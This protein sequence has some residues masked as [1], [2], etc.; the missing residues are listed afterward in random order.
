MGKQWASGS[1]W[2]GGYGYYQPAQPDWH[3]N[4]NATIY[5]SNTS[6]T[7]S[8][9]FKV[10][11][12]EATIDLAKKTGPQTEVERMLAAVEAVCDLAR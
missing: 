4:S 2:N 5:A 11:D 1:S 12:Q 3:Y 9:T 6:N 8:I 10:G 7:A